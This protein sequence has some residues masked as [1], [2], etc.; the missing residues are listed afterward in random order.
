MHVV[1]NDFLP[2]DTEKLHNNCELL[3]IV[4]LYL[5]LACWGASACEGTKLLTLKFYDLQFPVHL[6]NQWH[7]YNEDS[8]GGDPKG[9]AAWEA[10]FLRQPPG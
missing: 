1:Q 9:P 4:H 3:K 2:P 7:N 6:N 5:L 10:S 8:G